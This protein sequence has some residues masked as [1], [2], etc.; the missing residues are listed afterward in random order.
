MRRLFIENIQQIYNLLQD[1]LS[2]EIF[3]KRLMYSLTDDS[4]YIR[5]IICLSEIGNTIH[6]KLKNTNKNKVIFGS[7]EIGQKIHSFFNDIKFECFVDN[8]HYGKICNGLSVIDINTLKTNYSDALIIISTAKY[9]EEI[10]NQL[11]QEGFKKENIINIGNEYKKQNHLQ[12][13][14][15]PVLKSSVNKKEIFV[16]GGCYD[17]L[18]ACE[19]KKWCENS[20]GVEELFV[21]AWEPDPQSKNVCKE[22]LDIHQIQYTLINKGLW[23]SKDT[24]HFESDKKSSAIS[25]NGTITIEVDS[26]DNIINQPVTYIKLDVEGSEYEALLGAEGTIK[27]YKPKLAVCV[28][29]KS[30]DIWELPLLIHKFNPDYKFYLR[31][32][33]FADNETVLYAIDSNN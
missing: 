10:F 24:L 28:Y 26:I 9:S 21:Y 29:H 22:K 2:K 1:D 16:D 8:K 5:E 13:F 20:G 32:Y 4:R 17:A 25:K 3:T 7:G 12:Y 30:E 14:D 31:H 19:F 27:K 6:Q 33:S 15:L 18:N 11:L 23:S